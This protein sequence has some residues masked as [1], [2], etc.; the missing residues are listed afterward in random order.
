MTK[1]IIID[2][3]K[4]LIIHSLFIETKRD[5]TRCEDLITQA[6]TERGREMD[7][8][9]VSMGTVRIMEPNEPIPVPVD[10]PVGILGRPL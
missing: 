4:E 3:E 5:K 1:I 7:R 6:V 8:I 9:I 10:G 2:P